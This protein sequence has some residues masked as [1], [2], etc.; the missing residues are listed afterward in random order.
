LPLAALLIFLA[1]F[2]YV[3]FLTEA[4]SQVLKRRASRSREDR[5]ER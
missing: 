2:L 4:K 1:V 3:V 5:D